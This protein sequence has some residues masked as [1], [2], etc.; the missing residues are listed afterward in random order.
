MN[1][2]RFVS[3]KIIVAVSHNK[4]IPLPQIQELVKKL[5]CKNV[6]FAPG[7]YDEAKIDFYINNTG[8][9]VVHGPIAD[10]GLTGRKVVCDTYGGY[11]PVGGGSQS[12]KDY[13]KVDRSAL[14][15][16][17]WIAKHIVAAGLA[18]K[19]LVQLSYV[20]AEPKPTSLSVDT[21]GTS[22]TKMTDEVLSEK[23]FEKFELTPR[24]ITDKFNLDKPSISNFLYADIAAKGQ[25]GYAAYPWE[26]LDM[27]EWFKT[28]KV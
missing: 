4:D 28:L 7:H 10:S 11:A 20:I 12:S 16:S 27:L 1:A 19:A 3:Q 15:A 6:S 26:Q 9:F 22:L 23:I 14:Y 17:R 13:S 8:R 2:N 24:W 5:I 25:V 21:L 18:K